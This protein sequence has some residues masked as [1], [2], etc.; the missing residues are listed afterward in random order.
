MGTRYVHYIGSCYSCG[1]NKSIGW[2]LNHGT[3]YALCRSCY[4]YLKRNRGI[5][6]SIHEHILKRLCYICGNNST[7]YDHHGHAKWHLNH[8]NQDNVICSY[9]FNLYFNRAYQWKLRFNKRELLFHI[10]GHECVRCGEYDKRCL[11]FDHINGGGMK[12]YD[13]FQKSSRKFCEFY[14]AN[15][16]LAKETLQVLCSNCNWRKRYERRETPGGG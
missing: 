7:R 15:P 3:N 9:C 14:I 4:D 8:D 6:K 10:I 16:K 1:N 13:R 2:Y 5:R 12:D 11:H